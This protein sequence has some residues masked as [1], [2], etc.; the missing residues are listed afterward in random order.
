MNTIKRFL[1]KD[2]IQA[3]CSHHTKGIGMKAALADQVL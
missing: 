1:S 2:W 3:H